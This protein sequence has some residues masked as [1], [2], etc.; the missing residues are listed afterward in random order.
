M[1]DPLRPPRTPALVHF[2]GAWTATEKNQIRRV[3]AAAESGA[4]PA[5]AAEAGSPW[6]ATKHRFSSFTLYT[7]S[8]ARFWSVLTAQ[9]AQDLAEQIEAAHRLQNEAEDANAILQLVYQS[10]ATTAMGAEALRDLLH[11]AR[12]KNEASNITGVL[13]YKAKRFIQVLEGEE[14]VVRRLYATIKSD[15][16]HT[17][18][19]TLL[20][21][22]VRHRVFPG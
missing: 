21:T 5:T 11:E 4:L 3:A 20:T 9:H 22:R 8:R 14:A 7:A 17:E 12:P 2:E 19:E 6:V 15:A 16:R 10:R 13:L 18:V 1:S